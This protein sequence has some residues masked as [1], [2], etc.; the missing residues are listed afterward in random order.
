VTS[1]PGAVY[2]SMDE[3]VADLPPGYVAAPCPPPDP[4][5][6]CKI[7]NGPKRLTVGRQCLRCQGQFMS[8]GKGNRLCPRCANINAESLDLRAGGSAAIDEE[9]ICDL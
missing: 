5:E 1:K 6:N 4:Q 8:E 9:K 3:L 2:R 7:V